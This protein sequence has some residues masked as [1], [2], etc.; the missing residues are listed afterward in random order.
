[1]TSGRGVEG[2]T[3]ITRELQELSI[4]GVARDVLEKLHS[5]PISLNYESHPDA[6][7]AGEDLVG[8][9]RGI[10]NQAIQVG[11][12]RI[13][14]QLE[15]LSNMMPSAEAKVEIASLI[16]QCAQTGL[17]ASGQR[18]GIGLQSHASNIGRNRD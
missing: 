11:Q 7:N 3:D 16:G 10:E 12:P 14:Q 8:M 13:A 17:S 15:A 6:R 2:R 9:L 4:V 1:M 5:S 18:L